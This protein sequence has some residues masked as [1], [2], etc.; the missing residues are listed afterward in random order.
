MRSAA[1][2]SDSM[3]AGIRLARKRKRNFKW[4]CIYPEHSE[5]ADVIWLAGL[6]QEL[7]PL[8]PR[9]TI[10]KFARD[11]GVEPHSISRFIDT[12]RDS[13]RVIL[14]HGTTADRS[15]LI[16]EDGFRAN[17]RIW[18]T[19]QSGFARSHAIQRSN[20]R[21]ESAIVFRCNIDL[22]KYS[23]FDAYG[24]HYAF[25]H[26]RIS[27]DVIRTA[28]RLGPAWEDKGE[29]VDVTITRD[30]GK[31]EVMRWINH[32]MELIGEKEFS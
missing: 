1:Y 25:R 14:W 24:P 8:H 30:S 29:L 16:L 28:F 11:H 7:N 31:P 6:F 20:R 26:T 2:R 4:Q 10:E 15:R 23:D 27:R 18:F 19:R 21:G 9:L 22:A 3:K 5:D 12:E 13:N 32:C 17:G